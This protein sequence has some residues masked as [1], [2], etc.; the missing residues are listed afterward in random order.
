MHPIFWKKSMKKFGSRHMRLRRWI[1]ASQPRH[2][3]GFER[4]CQL[5]DLSAMLKSVG[6]R[7]YT[8]EKQRL[9]YVKRS[10]DGK[11]DG[12]SVKTRDFR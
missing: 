2:K 5:V 11:A 10:E 7:G 4:H 1:G 8:A 6:Y 12:I 9:E 3:E